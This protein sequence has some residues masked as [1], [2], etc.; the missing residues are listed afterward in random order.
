MHMRHLLMAVL[1]PTLLSGAPLLAAGQTTERSSS[2]TSGL[3]RRASQVERR[4]EARLRAKAT[5]TIQQEFFARI[6]PSL[7]A[8]DSGTKFAPALHLVS[9]P[10]DGQWAYTLRTA[11]RTQRARDI[12]K[13]RT[14]GGGVGADLQLTKDDHA[15]GVFIA[16]GDFVKV[17]DAF[18]LGAAT[19]EFDR[20][21]GDHVTLIGS[22]SYARLAPEEGA[23]QPT[24]SPGWPSRCRM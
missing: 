14:T 2:S 5:T 15:L 23:P 10:A 6:A 22:A 12:S 16:S 8:T 17:A 9:Q 13:S 21:I 11:F 18:D 7:E 4:E 20:N 3:E 19:L 1:V 24:S